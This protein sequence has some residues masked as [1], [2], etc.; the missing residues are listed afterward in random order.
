MS[1]P[2]GRYSFHSR[3]GPLAQITN[4]GL[5][6]ARKN[7]LR[8]FNKA[9]VIGAQPL[10]DGKMFEV[11]IEETTKYSKEKVVP[12]IGSLNIGWTASRPETVSLSD[13]TF[14]DTKEMGECDVICDHIWNFRR[15][16]IGDTVGIV[17]IGRKLKC[18]VNGQ[19]KAIKKDMK[20]DLPPVVYPIVDL[21]GEC[22]QVSI[23]SSGKL[24]WV[25][26]PM[27]S[28]YCS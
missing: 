1:I 14:G 10:E 17:R 24:P 9:V 16:D 20:D 19:A 25:L 5:T 21:Y 23:V 27:F 7:P 22:A 28:L 4:E 2:R 8:E 15:L 12:W 13:D 11:C 26:Y 18:Y 3:A 6:A